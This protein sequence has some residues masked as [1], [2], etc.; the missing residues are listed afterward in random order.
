L[1]GGSWS[2]LDVTK[3]INKLQGFIYSINVLYNYTNSN[4]QLLGIA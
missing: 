4:W 3:A 2:T 1:F